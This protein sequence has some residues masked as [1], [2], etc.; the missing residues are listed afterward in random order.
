MHTELA[1]ITRNQLN[2][3]NN[4]DTAIDQLNQPHE[5]TWWGRWNWNDGLLFH[6]VPRNWIFP[7]RITVKRMW[8]LWFFGHQAEGIRPY[9]FINRNLDMTTKAQRKSY[10]EAKH[11]INKLVEFIQ[12]ME[13]PVLPYSNARIQDLQVT[14]CDIIFHAVYP[15]F[16][17]T[18]YGDN[19]CNRPIEVSYATIYN[20]M[21][22]N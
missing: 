10:T 6:P 1:N 22:S 11:V 3:A 12:N 20:R 8:D 4:M 19:R 17:T 15:N 9:R 5:E 18:V 16:I 7:N 2:D 21:H 13:P 14:Q